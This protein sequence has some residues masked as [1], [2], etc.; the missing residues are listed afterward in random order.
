ML[1]DGHPEYHKHSVV[2]VAEIELLRH[3]AAAAEYPRPGP[4]VPTDS[5]SSRYLNMVHNNCTL[6]VEVHNETLS[7]EQIQSGAGALTQDMGRCVVVIVKATYSI[8]LEIAG[9]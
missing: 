9:K 1:V 2:H 4:P 8:I 6:R 7:G 5:G 3:A